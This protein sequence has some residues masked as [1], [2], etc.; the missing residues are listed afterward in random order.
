MKKLVMIALVICAVSGFA[1]KTAWSQNMGPAIIYSPSGKFDKSFNEMSYV[2]TQ[3]YKAD[4]GRDYRE[5]ET[6]TESQVGQA[7]QNFASRGFSPIV[8]LSNGY[9]DQMERVARDFPDTKFMMID[10]YIDLPNV[11]SVEFSE[12]EG[13][14]LVG[15]VAGMTSKSKIIGF[16]GGQD[17][18]LIRKF[19]CGYAQ[20]AFAGGAKEV[21]RTMTGITVTAF[22]DP[23]KGGEIARSQMEQ[24]ADVIFAAAGGTGIGVLQAVADGGKLAIGVDSNQNYMFPGTMLT[25]MVKRVDIATYN[26]FR[27]AEE[28][29]WSGGSIKFGTAEGGVDWALDEYNRDLI[30]PEVEAAVN[31][32]RQKIIDGEIIV[33]DYTTGESCPV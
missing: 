4:T 21:I 16:V 19:A 1:L 29:N 6:Q 10:A 14:Y 5:F 32:A 23:V 9:R 11:R 12:H 8:M 13:S 7:I 20:G 26:T 3:K 33:H 30:T 15:L 28:G 31:E 22:N 27:D 2:G 25:S 24:G 17:I 18:P